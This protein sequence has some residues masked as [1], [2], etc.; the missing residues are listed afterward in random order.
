MG[1]LST[2]R[3][4]LGLAEPVDIGSESGPAVSYEPVFPRSVTDMEKRASAMER[5][6]PVR[7]KGLL[8]G[9]QC[10][11][12]DT[13][14]TLLLPLVSWKFPRRSITYAKFMGGIDEAYIAVFDNAETFFS[15][16]AEMSG[17][18]IE[19]V[20]ARAEEMR[21][22]DR[23]IAGR[24]HVSPAEDSAEW[25]AQLA[26]S[27]RLLGPPV[28]VD[29]EQE[30]LEAMLAEGVDEMAELERLVEINDS[31]I[32]SLDGILASLSAEKAAEQ[33]SGSSDA[34]ANVSE[35]AEQ[36]SLYV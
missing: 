1:F 5:R 14:R 32:Q 19:Q 18:L 9:R 4:A 25:E 2:M 6:H 16:A 34:A 36:L 3:D 23:E 17:Q 31:I 21:A 20:D 28:G 33:A 22:L 26:A 10:S 11:L 29:Y 15:L 30:A 13:K 8:V 12:A 35:L 27:H 7:E 24:P